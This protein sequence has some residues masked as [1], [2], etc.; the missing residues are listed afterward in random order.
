MLREFDRPM[1]R[2]AISSQINKILHSESFADKDQLQ[3]LLEILFNNIDAPTGLKPDRVIRE[4]WPEEVKT[5]RPADVATEMNRLRRVLKTYYETE[6]QTDSILVALPNRSAATQDGTKERRWIFAEPRMSESTDPATSTSQLSSIHSELPIRPG[7]PVPEPSSVPR[8]KSRKGLIAAAVLVAFSVGVYVA[9]RALTA[10]NRPQ[11]GRIDN[12][13]LVIMNAEGKELWRKTFPGGFWSK[14]Y[15]DGLATNLYYQDGL[16]THFWFGDLAG[17]GH[18]DV[19][20]LYHP[21]MDP[22]SHSTTLICYS[23]TGKE[24][25]RWNPG[26]D[27]PELNPVPS[28]YITM[29]FGVLPAPH[30]ERRR[31]VVMSRHEYYYPTQIAIVDSDGK[32]LSEYWH[33]GHLFHFA[34]ATLAGQGEIVAS[35]ISN[36]YHQATLLVL[37]PDHVSGASTELSRP[38]VQIHGMGAPHERFRLLFPRSDLNKDLYL[39]NEGLGAVVSPGRIQIDVKECWLTVPQGCTIVYGFDE[40]FNLLSADAEDTFLNAHKEYYSKNK[41]DHPFSS[42]EDAQFKKV[43]CLAGCNSEFVPDKTP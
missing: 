38:E 5:K 22:K 28:V 1:E 13:E 29:G 18:T 6:G 8:V 36:G 34:L 43:S 16:D 37:D 27:L 11:S 10:D 12:S 3:R 32:T 23:D 24:K 9:V 30:N 33:S 40:N 26:R 31:I 21:A 20:L 15:E 35:G 7:V 19:L 14:Y 4:L 25:W 42:D 17:D 39:Y 2:E 41:V